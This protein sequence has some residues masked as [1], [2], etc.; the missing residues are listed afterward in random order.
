MKVAFKRKT[1]DKTDSVNMTRSVKP[2]DIK[3]MDFKNATFTRDVNFY[4]KKGEV[5]MKKATLTLIV[6]DEETDKEKKISTKEIN[7][8][9]SVGDDSFVE[10]NIEFEIKDKKL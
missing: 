2:T 8:A 7:L 10:H 4:S 9:V 3:T 5:L 1:E 6:V